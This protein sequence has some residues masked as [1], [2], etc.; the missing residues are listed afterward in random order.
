MDTYTSTFKAF[1]E[2]ASAKVPGI[3]V[4]TSFP[5]KDSKDTVIQMYYYDSI[6]AFFAQPR[7][8]TGPVDAAIGGT[9]E[10]NKCAVYGGWTE[11]LKAAFMSNPDITSAMLGSLLEVGDQLQGS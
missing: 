7:G 3:K 11:E 8:L 6:D 10:T 9:K 1:A 2:D 5:K 4:I